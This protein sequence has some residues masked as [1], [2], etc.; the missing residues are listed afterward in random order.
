[1]LDINKVIFANYEKGGN[2]IHQQD[3]ADVHTS[4]TSHYIQVCT[5]ISL[6]ER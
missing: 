6:Y 1:M 5:V 2:K 3:V 4:T